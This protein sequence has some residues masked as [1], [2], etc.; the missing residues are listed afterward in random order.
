KDKEE[1]RQTKFNDKIMKHISSAYFILPESIVIIKVNEKEQIGVYIKEEN[2][3]RL[4]KNI[5]E[6]IWKKSQD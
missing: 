5:F 2:T 6:E 1:L 3:A 4:Q